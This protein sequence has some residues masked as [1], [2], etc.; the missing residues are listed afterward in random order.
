[1]SEL[2]EISKEIDGQRD[3]M[4]QHLEFQR[5]KLINKALKVLHEAIQ[6]EKGFQLE[7]QDPS[8]PATTWET[9]MPR[10]LTLV[11]HKEPIPV[12]STSHASNDWEEYR[13]DGKFTFKLKNR[14]EAVLAQH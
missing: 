7:I 13:S 3:L 1:M 2:T 4:I 6:S 14:W 9:F 5:Q 12:A 8:E 10:D 11:E